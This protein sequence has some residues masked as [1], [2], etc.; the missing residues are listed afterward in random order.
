MKAV[1]VGGSLCR[2]FIVAITAKLWDEKF[3]T[4]NIFEE[5][6]LSVTVFSMDEVVCRS[7]SCLC[8]L[9]Y[10][11]LYKTSSGTYLNSCGSSCSKQ[12]VNSKRGNLHCNSYLLLLDQNAPIKRRHFEVVVLL[13][14]KRL[15]YGHKEVLVIMDHSKKVVSTGTY[16]S[17]AYE[18]CCW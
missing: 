9:L 1:C 12:Q 13:G 6:Q 8:K 14:L 16:Y 15:S 10:N 7:F 4:S 18:Y 5:Q 2:S 3:N 17:K 11:T